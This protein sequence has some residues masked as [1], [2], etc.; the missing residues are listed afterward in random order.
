MSM[1]FLLM[2]RDDGPSDLAGMAVLSVL[3]DEA[4]E[5]LGEALIS[6]AEISRRVR[7]SECG[8]RDVLSRLVAD[9]W[10]SVRATCRPDGGGAGPDLYTLELGRFMAQRRAALGVSHGA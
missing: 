5:L 9:G 2:V 6:T 8:V 10:V 4:G 1:W 7:L 3:A